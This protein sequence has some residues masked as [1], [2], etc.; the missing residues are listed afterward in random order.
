MVA[1]DM[2]QN[3]PETKREKAASAMKE[4]PFHITHKCRVP[5]ILYP[6][7]PLSLMGILHA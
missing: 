5:Y 7:R 2:Q 1:I 6:K 3:D 4:S